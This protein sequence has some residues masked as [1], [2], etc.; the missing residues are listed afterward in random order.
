MASVSVSESFSTS[1]VGLKSMLLSLDVSFSIS[2]I[3][4]LNRAP[5]L[6]A[7]LPPG[8]GVVQFPDDDGAR[9]TG[10]QTKF[11]QN[12]FIQIFFHHRRLVAVLLKNGDGADPNTPPA[13]RNAD[14]G[15]HIHIH[16]NELAG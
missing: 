1:P 14:A 7:A 3:L 16:R 15:G 11:A 12:T 4:L 13:S 8:S 2:A 6:P 5:A 9:I 10:L